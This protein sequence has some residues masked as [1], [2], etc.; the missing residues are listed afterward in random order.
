MKSCPKCLAQNNNSAGFCG[1]CGE[2]LGSVEAAQNTISEQTVQDTTLLQQNDNANANSTQQNSETSYGSAQYGNNPYN[3]NGQQYGGTGY[4][5][6]QQ[7]GNGQY[8]NGQQYG[9]NVAYGGTYA[10]GYQNAA[11]QGYNNQNMYANPG[12]GGQMYNGGAIFALKSA[13]SSKVFL[14]AAIAFSISLA[15][16]IVSLISMPY[17]LSNLLP[18]VLTVVG[19]WQIYNYGKNVQNN[20]TSG[21]TI[22]KVLSIIYI[23]FGF[24]IVACLLI[25]WVALE[26]LMYGEYADFGSG[27]LAVIMIAFLI[28][29]AIVIAF[30]FISVKAVNSIKST[31]LTGVPKTNGVTLLSVLMFISSVFTILG[32]LSSFATI[33]AS[34][35]LLEEYMYSF[36]SELG[37]E[38]EALMALAELSWMSVLTSITYGVAV[39]LLAMSLSDY[40]KKIKNLSYIR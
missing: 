37:V 9:N 28:G 19:F 12:M 33:G 15:L 30:Y 23:G 29:I 14:A 18:Q 31:A 32:G 40:S 34:N 7:Y 22:M 3:S 35:V 17:T 11:G 4:N 25:A 39:F 20:S 8:N 2:V 27:I 26:S 21:F 24:L 13:C 10:S 6:T 38:T 16:N 5:N 1:A 36:S